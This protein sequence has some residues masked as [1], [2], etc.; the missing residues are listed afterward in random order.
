MRVVET[1]GF[2]LAALDVRENSRVH[3]LAICQLLE[4]AALPDTRFNEW[5]E[6]SGSLSSI[7]SC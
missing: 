2:H 5:D 7:A 3:D 1:F 4:A 6:A